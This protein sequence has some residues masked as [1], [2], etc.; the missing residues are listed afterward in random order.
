MTSTELEDWRPGEVDT[1]P[2]P[3]YGMSVD[4]RVVDAYVQGRLAS[5]GDFGE[6]LRACGWG[7]HHQGWLLAYGILRTP[8]EL[9]RLVRDSPRGLSTVAGAWWR[10]ASG[11]RQTR[12][13]VLAIS[14]ADVADAYAD[15]KRDRVLG[16]VLTVLFVAVVAG[17]TY[18]GWHHMPFRM[19]ASWFAVTLALGVVARRSRGERVLPRPDVPVERMITSAAIVEAVQPLCPKDQQ[20]RVLGVPHRRGAGWYAIVQVPHGV[21]VP[22]VIKRRAT[23]A[24][25]LKVAEDRV[26]IDPLPLASADQFGLYVSDHHP[27]E[28][29]AGVSPVLDATRTDMWQGVPIGPSVDGMVVLSVTEAH[30]MVAGATGTGKSHI[31]R[32]I[33]NAAVLDPLCEVVVWDFKGGADFVPY[34][35]VIEVHRGSGQVNV[36]AFAAWLRW[37]VTEELPRREQALGDLVDAELTDETDLTRWAAER[38]GVSMLLVVADE[39]QTPLAWGG[40]LAQQAADDL[41]QV[42]RTGRALG[43]H[44]VLATQRPDSQ[45]VD[46]A[47]RAQC[48]TKVSLKVDN[49]ESSRAALGVRAESGWQADTLPSEPKGAAIALGPGVKPGATRLRCFKSSVA[50]ART[51]VARVQP[52]PVN[53]PELHLVQDRPALPEVL[54]IA[55]AAWPNPG[56][57]AHSD[58]LAGDIGWDRG[59]LV[60]AMK[61]E[62]V[63]HEPVHQPR[64]DG[65][66]T[67]QRGFR[68]ADVEAAARRYGWS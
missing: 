20:A 68:L 1:D 17:W 35:N 55:L 47:L 51:I 66:R 40:K 13:I 61:R 32:N 56:K 3:I 43:V 22:T 19:V 67:T 58:I 46:T 48:P 64:T 62:G 44:L 28:V 7:V 24:Q 60:T 39:I 26:T 29:D 6:W 8:A 65:Q 59:D 27:L 52:K 31:L 9:G 37:L 36:E 50:D 38:T 54:R 4:A 30:L 63:A 33:V 53:R 41:L 45:A 10:W 18:W 5:L 16:G 42:A 14:A 49:P 25:G 12:R 21:E 15:Q 23:V 57:D 34:R 2:E 11:Q